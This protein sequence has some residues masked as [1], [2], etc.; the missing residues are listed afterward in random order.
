MVV[1]YKKNHVSV[2]YF[3]EHIQYIYF[4]FKVKKKTT[5]KC[6]GPR[7]KTMFV[8]TSFVNI[9]NI[10]ILLSKSRKKPPQNA[11]VPKT[12]NMK[13]IPPHIPI[14]KSLDKSREK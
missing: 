2:H 11:V 10:F 14:Y 3:D 1:Q 8:S 5:A 4:T 7:K 13:I 12:I 9:Y 6:S